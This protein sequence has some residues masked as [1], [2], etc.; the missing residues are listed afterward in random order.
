[1]LRRGCRFDLR[2][3]LD[4]AL[5]NYLQFKDGETQSDWRDLVSASIEEQLVAVR[6]PGVPLSREARKEEEHALLRKILRKHESREEQVRVWNERTAK[7]AR[8]F[9]RRLAEMPRLAEM[10]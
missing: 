9:Y 1:M 4:K 3:F 5:P 10:Q 2:L 6:H 7:S 8:A